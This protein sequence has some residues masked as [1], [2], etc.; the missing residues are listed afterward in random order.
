MIVILL[1]P[2][3]EVDGAMLSLA[4]RAE[5]S[6]IARVVAD[7]AAGRSADSEVV[8]LMQSD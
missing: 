7:A 4:V 6:R 2:I 3:P 1:E 8:D 5:R